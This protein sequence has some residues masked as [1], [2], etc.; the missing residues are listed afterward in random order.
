VTS[1]GH[2]CGSFSPEPFSIPARQVASD[3]APSPGKAFLFSAV[4]PGA[5]QWH[6]G[7]GRWPAYLAVEIWAWIQF[8]DWRR[9]GHRLQRQYKDLAWLVA[10]RISTGRRTDAGWDYYEALTQFQASGAFDTDPL[11][12]GIQPESDPATFNGTIWALA[13]QIF[14]PEDPENPIAPDSPAYDQAFD[15]YRSR[16]YAP[17]LAWDWGSNTL[18]QEEYGNLIREADEALRSATGMV[19]VIIANHLLSAVDALVSGRLGMADPDGPRVQAYLVPGPF[20]HQEVGL[21]V[22]LPTPFDHVP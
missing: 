3:R 11:T 12:D 18:H 1:D 17:S 10:R 7:Q 4:V 9:E 22:R 20:Y 5:G 8:L 6:L 2:L 13:Q 15:Y 19:G 16:A 14:L 21:A